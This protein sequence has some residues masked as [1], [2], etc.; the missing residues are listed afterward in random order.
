MSLQVPHG[1]TD[2]LASVVA[3]PAFA[4]TTRRVAAARAEHPDEVYPPEG[5]VFRAL[6]L[7]PLEAVRVVIVGQDPYPRPGEAHGLAFSFLGDQDDL[8]ASLRKIRMELWDDVQVKAP[9]SGSLEPWALDGVLL[10]NSILTVQRGCAGSHRKF[11][12]QTFTDAVIRA[13][14]NKPDPVVFLLWGKVAQAKAHLVVPPHVPLLA[15]H[16][17]ARLSRGFLGKHPFSKAN[18]A[19]GKRAITWR[20]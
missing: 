11:G 2:A 14:A 20:L 8:P 7:T 18:E 9:P 6:E 10:L 3:S 17:V 12:W 15:P 13:V 16:P 5:Q 19:L 4:E 1:W